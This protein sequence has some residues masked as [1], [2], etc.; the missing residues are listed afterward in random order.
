MRVSLKFP[1]WE[2]VLGDYKELGFGNK[3]GQGLN[4]SS[5]FDYDLRQVRSSL[6]LNFIISIKGNNTC[7]RAWL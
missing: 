4:L 5:A 3:S 1:P 2:A 7:P 6:T